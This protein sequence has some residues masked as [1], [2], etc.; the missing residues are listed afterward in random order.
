MP[1]SRS[2]HTNDAVSRTPRHSTSAPYDVMLGSSSAEK[3]LASST[4]TCSA[5]R[6]IIGV[7]SQGY[8]PVWGSGRRASSAARSLPPGLSAPGAASALATSDAAVMDL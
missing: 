8:D 6:A 2:H 3:P 4:A 7:A 1:G 5:N